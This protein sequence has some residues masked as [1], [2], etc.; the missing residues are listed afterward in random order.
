METSFETLPHV[1]VKFI[2]WDSMIL[3]SKFC[4]FKIMR[5]PFITGC[6]KIC[7]KIIRWT[8]FLKEIEQGMQR[9][10]NNFWW[11]LKQSPRVLESSYSEKIWKFPKHRLW[12]SSHS[13]VADSPAIVDNPQKDL[14][15][16][17]FYDS[18]SVE[19]QR[20]IQNS[21]KHLQWSFFKKIF[22]LS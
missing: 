19:Y 3:K 15:Q 12:Q 6:Q 8:Y 2:S 21:F 13:K 7:A 14:K 16:R 22:K 4:D 18:C 20:C 17:L 11:N 10:S 9:H 5:E 1:F